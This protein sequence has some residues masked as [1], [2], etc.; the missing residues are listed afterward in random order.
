MDQELPD[1][2]NWFREDRG[3]RDQ[4]ANIHWIME[5]AREFQKNIYYCFIDYP[6]ASVW[7]TA[8]CG[9][10][11]KSWKYQT[12]LPVSWETC[13]WIKKQKLEPD[14]DQL[15][16][17]ELGKEYDKTVYCHPAYLTSMLSTSCTMYTSWNQGFQE[18]YQQ[19][20]IC[21]WYHSNGRKQRGTKEHLDEGER[22]EWKTWLKT[23]KLRSW[24]L[25]PSLHGK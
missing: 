4:I 23:Q 18:K 16:G 19:L 14:M 7:I 10:F 6:E 15:N 21:S 17:S 8:N 25:V 24:Y 11:L 20:Q 9:K 13:M 22:G 5:K 3:T 2:Q 12:T 1:V